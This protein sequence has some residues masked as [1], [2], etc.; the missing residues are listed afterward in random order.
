MSVVFFFFIIQAFKK[1]WIYIFGNGIEMCVS[2]S[3]ANITK[4]S[5]T[6]LGSYSFPPLEFILNHFHH[7]GRFSI[8]AASL[9]V[10]FYDIQFN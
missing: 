5:R 2:V 8:F 9:I 3:E 7:S 1:V 4:G 10:I 6:L